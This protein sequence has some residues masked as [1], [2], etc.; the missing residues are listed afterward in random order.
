MIN[1]TLIT[2]ILAF[3]VLPGLLVL[4]ACMAAS[5]ADRQDEILRDETLRADMLQDLIAVE[6]RA[7]NE[8]IPSV[9]CQVQFV[10]EGTRYV[11]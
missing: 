10:P 7:K 8:T 5:R 6:L 3:L 11:S 4:I 2:G 9:S 1:L